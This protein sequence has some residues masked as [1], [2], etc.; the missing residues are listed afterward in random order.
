MMR[1]TAT[2]VKNRFGEFLDRAQKE[3]I[4]V[5]RSGRAVAVLLA[6]DE[7][8]RLQTMDDHFWSARALEAE[9]SGFVGHE[10]AMRLLTERLSFLDAQESE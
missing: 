2:E 9:R 7:Y 1:A 6:Q 10:E 3:P 4:T 8:E 5:E